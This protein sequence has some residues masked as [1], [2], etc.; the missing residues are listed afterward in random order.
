MIGG[1]HRTMPTEPLAQCLARV[2]N[3]QRYLSLLWPFWEVVLLSAQSRG[4]QV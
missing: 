1:Q 2:S 4:G 3:E